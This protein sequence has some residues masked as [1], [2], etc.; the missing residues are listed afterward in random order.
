[1]GISF[2][3]SNITIT[4]V[5]ELPVTAGNGF[6][7]TTD[8]R[9]YVTTSIGSH[10]LYLDG[11]LTV[12]W[13]QCLEGNGGIIYI[14]SGGALIIDGQK[15]INTYSVP[16]GRVNLKYRGTS[17]NVD[18]G[19]RLIATPGNTAR[20]SL[21][22]TTVE[23]DS[24][25]WSSISANSDGDN[26]IETSGEVVRFLQRPSPTDR[27]IRVNSVEPVI[28]LR[29]GQTVVGLWLNFAGRQTSL[30]GYTPTG[31]GPEINV[32]SN[33]APDR[34][35]LEDYDPRYVVPNYYADV[36]AVLYSG[37]F[38][39]FQGSAVGTNFNVQFK[40]A[41]GTA[42]FSKFIKISPVDAD[43]A[44]IADAVIAWRYAA[45]YPA[46]HAAKNFPA[47]T[48][49]D[50]SLQTA[51]EGADIEIMLAADSGVE[52]KGTPSTYT[53]FI[54]DP[55]PGAESHTFVL[56]KFGYLKRSFTVSLSGTGTAEITEEF[57]ALPVALTE[58]Q[59]AAVTG[60]TVDFGTR[61]IEISENRNLDEIYSLV[62]YLET[63]EARA[64][65]PHAGITADGEVLDLNDFDLDILPGTEAG[66]GSVLTSVRT[67]GTITGTIS[68][69]ARTGSQ[70]QVEFS[71]L[72][73][74]GFTLAAE[75][76]AN[77][78]LS[79]DS[80]TAWAVASTS[81]SLL[82]LWLALD[83]VYDVRVSVPGYIPHEGSLDTAESESYDPQI[84]VRRA[85]GG[86]V[87]Y[88]ES[89]PA[90]QVDAISFDFGEG[91]IVLTNPGIDVFEISFPAAFLAWERIGNNPSI[92]ADFFGSTAYPNETATGYII[93]AESPLGVSLSDGSAG[94]IML[95]FTVVEDD[96]SDSLDRFAG[97][98]AGYQ[99]MYSRDYVAVDFTGTARVALTDD[100][101][102]LIL[103]QPLLG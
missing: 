103:T 73:P 93:P 98:S 3:G 85:I 102:N 54:D 47:I 4:G 95:N 53:Y 12:R 96:G 66:K 67:T 65:E 74:E 22:D 10:N 72:N 36:H 68:T 1:M 86:S 84:V 35:D 37:A 80:G 27:R 71:G 38:A 76:P 29:A 26:I 78:L 32:G 63:R 52:K 56:L 75:Y 42:E 57:A 24:T 40:D 6:T 51:E 9:G 2:D 11:E 31:D 83:T 90:D 55:T 45:A 82:R 99:I 48:G 89:A 50:L 21:I 23:I 59:A 94:S 101:R 7:V 77:V 46:G 58:A 69:P 25:D 92:V 8:A 91:K 14:R 20:L 30:R 81:E 100:D 62:E 43:G 16:M 97:N 18:G 49:H 41:Q 88:D 19:I 15:I 34:I 39:R 64:L 28:D 13:M 70:V 60:I 17:A 44:A 87:V 33:P 5:E 61:E 79:D